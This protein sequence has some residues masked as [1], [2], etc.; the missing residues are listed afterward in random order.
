MAR[1][2]FAAWPLAGHVYPLVSIASELQ[3]R[4]HDVAFYTGPSFLKLLEGEGFTVYPFRRVSESVMQS[5][6]G[7]VEGRAAAPRLRDA[8]FLFGRARPMIEAIPDVVADVSE[9]IAEWGADVLVCDP[10]M[11]GPIV[12]IG[13]QRRLPV[14]VA[15]PQIYCLI[16]GPQTVPFGFGLPSPRSPRTRL[17][18]RAAW[19]VTDLLA[20]PARQR[21]SQLCVQHGL[22]PLK[23]SVAEFMGRLPLYIVP[24]I[25]E[26]DF[27]RQDL[28]SSVHYV[29]PCVW[30]R[31]RQ[32][33]VPAWMAT[34]PTQRPWVHVTEGTIHK[35]DPFVLRAAAQGLA[36]APVELILTSGPQRDPDTLELGPRSTN[37]HVHQWASYPD[38]LPRCA[39]VVSAGGAGTVMAALQVGVPLVVVPTHWDKPDNAQ[40]LVEAGVAVRLAARQ[41]NPASMRAAVERVLGDPAYRTNA[42]H[43]ARRLAEAPGPRGA[44]ELLEALVP[45]GERSEVR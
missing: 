28:P 13:G 12:I 40:R 19:L 32:G 25:R 2:L 45:V 24:S 11:W 22:P 5:T 14:V 1:V 16:P 29:G 37:L 15:A 35:Q 33:E 39:V 31:S 27:D 34:V 43:I 9:T 17:L 42:Q 4:G 6:V 38:L 23:C 18:A 7:S 21:I 3:A 44:A 8:R 30:N 26:L 10:R 20:A 41:C 36:D